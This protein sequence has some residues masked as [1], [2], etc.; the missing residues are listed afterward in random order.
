MVKVFI[1]GI[2]L[3]WGYACAAQNSQED[4]AKLKDELMD[5]AKRIM[6][7]FS[8]ST[9]TNLALDDSLVF[10]VNV[11]ALGMNAAIC[12]DD[13]G[14]VTTVLKKNL[15][16][17]ERFYLRPKVQISPLLDS[18]IYNLRYFDKASATK[19]KAILIHEIVHYLQAV[20]SKG[21][22]QPGTVEYYRDFQE[23]EAHAVM[24]YYY[25]EKLYPLRLK[26][27]LNE[28]ITTRAIEILIDEYRLKDKPYLDKIFN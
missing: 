26:E 15:P 25:L 9:R 27:I 2:M 8:F 10:Q 7:I 19:A 22:D 6:S 11:A 4:R 16:Y 20:I 5:E 1:F 28:G 13:C 18:F 12:I 21:G 14:G 17:S 23:W 24:S 3:I